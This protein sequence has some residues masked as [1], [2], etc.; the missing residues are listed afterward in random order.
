LVTF[1]PLSALAGSM[2][3]TFG[4]GRGGWI[5]RVD[6]FETGDQSWLGPY[7]ASAE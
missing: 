3:I 2:S 6:E 1:S 5:D 4:V 7:R